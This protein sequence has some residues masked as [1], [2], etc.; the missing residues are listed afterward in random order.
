MIIT[1]T[2]WTILK[3][4][5]LLA[6]SIY[7]VFAVVAIRQVQLMTSTFKTGFEL[8]LKIISLLHLGL[9]IFIFIIVIIIINVI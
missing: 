2:P 5:V 4:F 9:V 6:L 1:I 7:I 8:P 3:L